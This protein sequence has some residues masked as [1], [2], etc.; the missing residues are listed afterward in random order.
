MKSA[1]DN[2]DYEKALILRDRIKAL[3]NIQSKQNVEYANIK[4]ADVI[5]LVKNKNLIIKELEEKIH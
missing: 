1:S 3:T 5:A 4:S 2:L